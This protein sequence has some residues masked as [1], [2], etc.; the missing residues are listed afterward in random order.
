MYSPNYII[1]K[2]NINIILYKKYL[3]IEL[4]LDKNVDLI[5]CIPG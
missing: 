3:F 4:Y 2:I 1:F 5:I